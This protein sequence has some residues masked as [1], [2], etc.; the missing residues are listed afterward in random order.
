MR[1][2]INPH[3][4]VRKVIPILAAALVA[5][6]A[7]QPS[8]PG[9]AW[10]EPTAVGLTPGT[11][12]PRRNLNFAKFRNLAVTTGSVEATI[13]ALA[14][15]HPNYLAFNTLLYQSLS[16]QT[17]SFREPRAIVYGPDAR[18]VFTFNGGVH[19]RG[20]AAFE[21]MEYAA[22][23]GQFNFREILFKAGAGPRADYDL[24][25]R[26]IAF[27][28]A[29]V[30]ISTANPQKC[31]NCHGALANPIWATYF[32]WPG[33]YGSNFDN[34]YLNFNPNRRGGGNDAWWAAQTR[35]QSQGIPFVLREGAADVEVEGLYA[36]LASKSTHPR[37]RWLPRH[38]AE[39]GFARARAGESTQRINLDDEYERE[40]LARG[41]DDPWP[42]RPNRTLQLKLMALNQRRIIH[43]LE[44]AGMRPGELNGVSWAS[45]TE[46][47]PRSTLE[48]ARR[49]DG[50]LR[51]YPWRGPRPSVA[52][53]ERQFLAQV[54]SEVTMQR[55]K[56]DNHAH[57]FGPANVEYRAFAHNPPEY[58]FGQDWLADAPA[59]YR[60]ALNV[61]TE[62]TADRI[63]YTADG[64]SSATLVALELL[65]LNRG[66]DLAPY[67]LN[68]R[69]Q[70][71]TFYLDGL[72][73]V[74]DWLGLPR[75][76]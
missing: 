10:R 2:S 47:T 58:K 5:S 59:F 20:G 62:T 54:V 44:R 36:Y 64:D 40:R 76:I 28:D 14:Q 68:V 38:P 71:N 42:G 13:Y 4:I 15:S 6:C 43:A 52:E 33:A 60:R 63:A 72:R 35:P 49:I 17:G 26:E 57:V 73:D 69:Q 67:N 74:E 31:L 65:L 41:G 23:D 70:A 22:A 46:E 12:D 50:V 21:T 37:Y 30:V 11:F 66:F 56:F 53:I 32:V 39:A 7:G 27:E 48:V 51:M 34:L 55:E 24:A 18:F 75:G 3:A 61:T 16:L 45:L 29:R 9:A 1:I 8:R 19:Q 25:P